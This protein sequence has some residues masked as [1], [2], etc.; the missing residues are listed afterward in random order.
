MRMFIL[1]VLLALQAGPPPD[2]KVKEE[3]QAL[4][5]QLDLENHPERHA[6][7]AAWCLSKKWKAQADIHDLESRRYQF[8][9]E[10]EKLKAEPMAADLKRVAELAVKMKLEIESTAAR[11]A[12]LDAEIK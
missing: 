4:V 5:K 7:A 10:N 6:Q 9:K 3:Y 12:W 2:P 8:R 11:G 1:F